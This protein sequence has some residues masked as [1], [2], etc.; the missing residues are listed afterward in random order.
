M[1]RICM[2]I[3]WHLP[4]RIVRW[5]FVRVTAVATSGK[6][7]STATPELLA[8]DALERWINASK[9]ASA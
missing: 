5:C 1:D 7:S 3:A 4:E 6:Y 9:D 2:W 8:I